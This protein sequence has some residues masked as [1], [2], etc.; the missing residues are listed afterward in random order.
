[1]N[2]MILAVAC[3]IAVG[4]ANGGETSFSH[5][6]SD[7]SALSPERRFVADV[8]ESRMA[9]RLQNSGGTMGTTLTVVYRL[10]PSLGGETARVTVKGARAE[11]AAAR[12]RALFYGVARL[13]VEMRW[14][15]Q[16][17]TLADGTW[18]VCPAKSVRLAY[19]ARH[20]H[21]WYHMATEEELKRYAEDM[22]L[23][24]MN[25][26]K[27]QY[28]YPN[29][30]RAGARPEE[31]AEFERISKK[32]YD[33]LQAM[34]A[35]YL[36]GGGSNQVPAD[37]PEEFRGVPE[38]D[39]KRGN[40]GFNACPAKPK[41]LE[42]MLRLRRQALADLARD[43]VK[44]GWF[45]HWPFDEGGC[46]CDA[47]RPWGGNGF[48]GLC[49]RYDALNKAAVPDVKTV[50]AT[51]VFHDDDYEGLWK[52]LAKPESKWIDGLM[53]DSHGDF[54]KYALEHPLPRKL[55]IITFPEI[56]MYRRWPWGGYG[57]IAMPARFERLFRQCERVV[58]GFMFYS[59][60]LSEDVNKFIVARLYS[61][62]SSDWQTIIRDY[63]RLFLPGIAPDDFVRYCAMLEE[64]HEFPI[65]NAQLCG[66]PPSAEFFATYGP[67]TREI[68][69]FAEKLDCD[70]LPSCRT[71]WR[72]R[73][74]KIRADIDAHTA[75]SRKL[76]TPAYVT[77]V[78]ELIEMYHVDPEEGYYE[79]Y[80]NQRSV[81]PY[82]PNVRLE[83]RPGETLEFRVRRTNR[84]GG[85]IVVKPVVK[86]VPATFV[87][88]AGVVRVDG[89]VD[90][91]GT[92]TLKPGE[93]VFLAGR[94]HVPPEAK[95]G[96]YGGH[97][98]FPHGYE[99]GGEFWR[100]SLEVL[101]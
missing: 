19:W 8:L 27:Y 5:V 49:R 70:I 79:D 25:G 101:P 88:E 10:D 66:E 53:I 11:I 95:V 38:T 3:T 87:G 74:L 72:W 42:L 30:N 32:V 82:L 37:S 18:E 44:P 96:H 94:I 91:T 99:K 62:P 83:G 46:E 100:I 24:G 85:D 58:D 36:L 57:A 43:G 75:S 71:G 60:G 1:M 48:I 22:M 76:L 2:R 67:R 81:R 20:F 84:T 21:N 68:A 26:F 52:Y 35:D 78:R 54:P 45:L 47:C 77:M 64:S 90:W 56:S 34:D 33:Y 7:V 69:A 97:N 29:V 51:W 55:P 17:F 9:E 80:T 41:A 23:M 39:E 13:M 59:E 50:L 6:V 89:S 12:F 16:A 4:L 14:T 86:C 31:I 92:V 98:I 65:Q 15:S 61:D 63:A 28:L 73:Q 93:S 40:L